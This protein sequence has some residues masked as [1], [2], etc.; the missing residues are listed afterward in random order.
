MD[1]MEAKEMV[2]VAVVGAICLYALYLGQA[3]LA[4][5]GL[6]GVLGYL[7]AT[8]LPQQPQYIEVMKDGE[9]V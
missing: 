5:I 6:A 1:N 7:G 9:E 4:G 2:A 3:Q 8:Y